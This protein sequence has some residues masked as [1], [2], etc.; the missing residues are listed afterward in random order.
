M[1]TLVNVRLPKILYEDAQNYLLK[2]GY[3]NMQDLIKTLLREYAQNKK[4]EEQLTQLFGSPKG[5]K[6]HH[7]RN[8]QH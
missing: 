5:K 8:S 3:T 6:K 1:N 2:D 7:I 4:R